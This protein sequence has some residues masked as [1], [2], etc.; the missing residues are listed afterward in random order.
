MRLMVL[1]AGVL[2]LASAQSGD[3]APPE[4]P[5]HWWRTS[6][7]ADLP[8]LADCVVGRNTQEA[9]L[10][11]RVMVRRT[12]DRTLE[13]SRLSVVKWL[14]PYCTISGTEQRVDVF[15]YEKNEGRL[16]L[17]QGGCSTTGGKTIGLIHDLNDTWAV[18]WFL[19]HPGKYTICHRPSYAVRWYEEATFYLLPPTP[20]NC[21]LLTNSSAVGG[22]QCL[23]PSGFSMPYFDGFYN[24]MTERPDRCVHNCAE[25]LALDGRCICHGASNSCDICA[26]CSEADIQ[27][28][29]CKCEQSIIESLGR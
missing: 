13:P 2:P 14:S 18:F 8:G 6:D 15:L 12:E 7:S 29:K 16:G 11:S 22:V 10:F 27:A 21:G 9:R 19:L 1:A 24:L 25:C 4:Q 23:L 3:P 20:R 5:S 26:A 28:Q 17:G